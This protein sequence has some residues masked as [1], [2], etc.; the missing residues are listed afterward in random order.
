M[1]LLAAN[2]SMSNYVTGEQI[3]TWS[4]AFIW[5]LIKFFNNNFKTASLTDF[6]CLPDLKKHNSSENNDRNAVESMC[7]SVCVCARACVNAHPRSF[8]FWFPTM[9]QLELH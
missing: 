2:L 9:A 6:F 3:I 5:L 7:V 1:L 8:A 4:N